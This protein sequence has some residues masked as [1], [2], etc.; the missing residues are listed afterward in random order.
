VKHAA[1]VAIIGAG[2]YGL[3]VAAH[4]KARG[5]PA[6]VFGK[7]MEFW[8]NMPAGLYLK[9]AWSASSLSDPAGAYSLD[10]Y[11][12]PARH[13]FYP[14]GDVGPPGINWLVAFP[15]IFRHFPD[16]V[17]Y[18][19]HRRAVRP[20]GA[21]WLR[22]RIEGRSRLTAGTH[23]VKATEQGRGLCLELSD[24]AMREAD[25]LFLGTGYRPDIHRLTFIDSTLHRQV[26]ELDG[27]PVLSRWFESSVPHLYFV[28]ALA[29]RTFGPTCRFVSGA[30]APARQIARHV[31][32]AE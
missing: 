31:A 12:G 10:R 30:K 27:Y 28:G 5:I 23:I 13:S 8:Q 4:L 25:F 20:G 16:N 15:K 11:T 22:P 21:K 24:G 32:Q 1:S 26:Q 14:P 7:P 3:S 6:L 17:K 9:S 18:L 19:V 29:G 2:P